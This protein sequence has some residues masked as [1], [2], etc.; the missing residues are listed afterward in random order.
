MNQ[1]AAASKQLARPFW[2]G[3]HGKEEGRG[4]A[5]RQAGIPRPEVEF[6]DEDRPARD[7][8]KFLQRIDRSDKTEKRLHCTN[9]SVEEF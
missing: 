8:V 9:F 4:L 6:R 3:S 5:V 1:R 7:I 2:V